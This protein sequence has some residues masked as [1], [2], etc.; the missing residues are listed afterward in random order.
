MIKSDGCAYNMLYIAI[1]VNN[2][3]DC[4]LFKRLL[5]KVIEHVFYRTCHVN[6]C[7]FNKQVIQSVEFICHKDRA[8]R[9]YY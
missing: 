3:D 9:L 7:S 5:N 1:A 4:Y 2:S 6:M 8:K